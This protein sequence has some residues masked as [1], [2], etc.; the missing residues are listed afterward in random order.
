VNTRAVGYV[1]VSRVARR[2]GDSFLSPEL[3]REPT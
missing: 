3:Q 2:E 1:H